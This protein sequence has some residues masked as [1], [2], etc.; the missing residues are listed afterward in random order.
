MLMCTVIFI[1]VSGQGINIATFLKLNSVRN[2]FAGLHTNIPGRVLCGPQFR[3]CSSGTK[4]SNACEKVAHQP[5][6]GLW[7]FL[8]GMSP[9]TIMTEE[10]FWSH[11]RGDA[12]PGKE[13]VSQRNTPYEATSV[14]PWEARP[15][16][17]PA[18]QYP[19]EAF[20]FHENTSLPL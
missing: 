13:N 1:A 19:T 11:D 17:A 4:V 9:G 8:I 16:P 10:T 6:C 18:P 2:S 7:Y 12:V 5:P 20:C 3:K 14:H 15:I